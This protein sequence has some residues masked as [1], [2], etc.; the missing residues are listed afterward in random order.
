MDS[1]YKYTFSVKTIGY[2]LAVSVVLCLALPCIAVALY[3][4]LTLLSLVVDYI[5][6]FVFYVAFG[7]FYIIFKP[8]IALSNYCDNQLGCCAVIIGP[9]IL[10]L[11]LK[12]FIGLFQGAYGLLRYLISEHPTLRRIVIFIVSFW[13]ICLALMFVFYSIDFYHSDEDYGMIIRSYANSSC[14]SVINVFLEYKVYLYSWTP[15][16]VTVLPTFFIYA[17]TLSYRIFRI[18]FAG[19]RTLLHAVFLGITVLYRLVVAG[20]CFI[21]RA[22]L[23]GIMIIVDWLFSK[24]KIRHICPNQDCGHIGYSSVYHCP[25]CGEL[26]TNLRPSFD[27]I[28]YKRCPSCNSNVSSSCLTGRD[29]YSTACP[30]CHNTWKYFNF[31]KVP[32]SVFIVEGAAKSG[33]TS[34]LV[35][36]LI[37]W[38]SLSSERVHFLIEEQKNTV[39]NLA[40][41]INEQ[42]FCPS[43][44][45]LLHPEAY[46]MHC[47]KRFHSFLAYF[48]DTG[49]DTSYSLQAGVA[50]PYFNMANGVFLVIDPW[51][52]RCVLDA[53]KGNN[54]TPP[55][56]YHYSRHDANVV[57][58]RLCSKLDHIYTRSFRGG[59]NI[60]ICIIV[61]KCD[62]NG[63]SERIGVKKRHFQSSKQ[64]AEQSRLVENYL[65]NIGM[66]NFVNVIKTRFK[67]YAFFAVSVL[68]GSDNNSDSVLNSV[69]WMTC[70]AK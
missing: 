45:R 13:L 67:K 70:N 17:S 25:H 16:A 4:L 49:G 52:E 47:K 7:P 28:F 50:E 53:F 6:P 46:V 32:S 10:F 62:I 9:F 34:L 15:V 24:R 44:T 27:G 3:A 18:L 26:L 56:T 59:F 58:G 2:A 54:F 5:G 41:S 60:P 38:S 65:V 64:W 29:K 55:Q 57:I 20:S 42:R 22:F 35:Q 33:K 43:T 39:K 61:T 37:H 66:Y 21:L 1:Q 14:R 48:Y 8:L 19:A 68:D 36:M 30:K 12:L 69:L 11:F 51:A 40:D 23:L 63:L 31:G